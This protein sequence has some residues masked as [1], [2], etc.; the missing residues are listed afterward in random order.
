MYRSQSTVVGNGSQK[1]APWY[2][3]ETKSVENIV[4]WRKSLGCL[5]F[6]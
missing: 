3:T 4:N 1:I 5:I 2:K 6:F